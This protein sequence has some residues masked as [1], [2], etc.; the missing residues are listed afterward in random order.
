MHCVIL[1]VLCSK[2]LN[3][4]KEYLLSVPAS[5]INVLYLHEA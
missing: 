4:K 2:N 1:S 3:V 5:L